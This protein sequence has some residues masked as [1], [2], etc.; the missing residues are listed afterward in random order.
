[1]VFVTLTRIRVLLGAALLSLC[2]ACG[3]AEMAV[4][5]APGTQPVPL[6]QLDQR[7]A[8]E[9]TEGSGAARPDVASEPDETIEE[10]EAA[11]VPEFRHPLL[12]PSSDG[13]FVPLARAN[14]KQAALPELKRVHPLMAFPTR[15]QVNQQSSARQ[16]VSQVSA[17]V[18]YVVM[19]GARDQGEGDG[20][21]RWRL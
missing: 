21:L 10:D 2:V 6:E 14:R 20:N 18:A 8:P 3:D 12:P 11:T 16:R 4:P 13:E 19:S 15:R 5:P 17:N 9:A 7:L 1:M